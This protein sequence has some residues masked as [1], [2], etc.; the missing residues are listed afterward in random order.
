MH[1]QYF[2]II[3]MHFFEFFNLI[4]FNI[5]FFKNIKTLKFSDYFFFVF[6]FSN[7]QKTITLLFNIEIYNFFS[8]IKK[9][10]NS[11]FLLTFLTERHIGNG[12]HIRKYFI[13]KTKCS[14]L[15]SVVFKRLFCYTEN[16]I[17]I[18]YKRCLKV[19]FSMFF[20]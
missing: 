17:I 4:F 5:T 14:S 2:W 3:Y 1:V 15:I 7:Y 20:S 11:N 6:L 8:I 18:S 13:C 9:L 19:L 16:T 12:R 10:F